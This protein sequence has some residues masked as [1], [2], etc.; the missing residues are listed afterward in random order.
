MRIWSKEA[1]VLASAG[2]VFVLAVG[3]PSDAKS[4]HQWKSQALATSRKMSQVLSRLHVLKPQQKVAKVRLNDAEHRLKV[5]QNALSDVRTQLVSTRNSL[6]RTRAELNVIEKRLKNRNDLLVS[7]VITN[8]K[9]GNSGYLN[10]L[11][12]AADFSDLMSR[13]YVVHKLV[14]TDKD[15][16][17]GFKRDKAAV[18]EHKA[19]LEVQEKRRASLERQQTILTVQAR[20]EKNER[21]QTLHEISQE[22]AKY[23]DQL[24][25]L[26]QNSRQISAM[27]RKMERTPQGRRRLAQT[28][29]GSFALPVNGQITSGFGM[30]YHPIIHRYKLHTGVDIGCRI[31]TPIHA[32]G[33]GVIVYAGWY[34]AYGNCVIIDHGGGITTL[35]GHQSRVAVRDGASVTKGSVIGYSGNTGWSTGPHCHFEKR[36]HGTPVSPF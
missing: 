10:V 32:A 23:E 34:G 3:Q 1:L 7:R 28:W 2:L 16:L 14:D 26:E 17:D 24:A 36:N 15:L 27:I 20:D 30:R 6:S 33:S 22:R 13:S 8:Y 12:G 35:Y 25:E 11:V 19:A 21:Q 31:G 29:H 5:T 4:L 9:Q 18:Q